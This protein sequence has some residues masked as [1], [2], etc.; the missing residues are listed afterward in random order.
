VPYIKMQSRLL[1]SSATKRQLKS[2]IREH[3]VSG[4]M[5]FTASIE[6]GE[7]MNVPEKYFRNNTANTLALI[8]TMLGVESQR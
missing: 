6:V 1:A 2:V 5:H 8:R 3:S 7:S 4:V